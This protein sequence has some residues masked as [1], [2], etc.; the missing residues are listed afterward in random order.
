MQSFVSRHQ[1]QIQGTLS[2]FDRL[3]FVGSLLRLS[4]REGLSTFLGA[5]GV[6]LKD[7]GNYMLKLSQADQAGQRTT[8]PGDALRA[9]PLP[10]LELAE[11][12]GLRPAASPLR[13]GQVPPV[14]SPYSVASSPAGPTSCIRNSQTKHLGLRPFLRPYSSFSLHQPNRLVF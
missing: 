10:P 3:R 12:G 2:G 6:L 7:F 13:S 8:R 4:Y 5:T 14:S 1:H 9:H 11:Q